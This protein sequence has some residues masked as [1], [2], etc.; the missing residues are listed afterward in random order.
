MGIWTTNCA[1]CLG[2][3]HHILI[4]DDEPHI[5]DVITFALAEAGMTTSVAHDGV[6]A[7]DVFAT[8]EPDLIVLDI[9]MNR[10]S[11][12]EE[13]IPSPLQSGE[14]LYERIREKYPKMRISI[15][16]A[17]DH[18]ESIN[19]NDDKNAIVFRKPIDMDIGNS[20][21]QFLTSK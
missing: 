16:T 15:I 20:V 4:V 8:R 9:M 18:L 5:C 6:A 12:L 14:Y 10:S 21:I 7:L 13:V 2:L 11:E 1:S 19:V 3:T 17:K